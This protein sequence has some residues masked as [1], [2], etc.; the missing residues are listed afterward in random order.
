MEVRI[1]L[2]IYCEQLKIPEKLAVAERPHMHPEPVEAGCA[3][4]FFSPQMQNGLTDF[5][6]EDDL[7]MHPEH[8]VQRLVSEPLRGR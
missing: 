4:A 3:D 7:L 8:Q 5:E 1:K 2:F 6:K